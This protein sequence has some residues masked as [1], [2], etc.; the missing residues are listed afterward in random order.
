MHEANAK[1]VMMFE[2]L[3]TDEGQLVAEPLKK[4]E[5]LNNCF[6]YVFTKE[7]TNIPVLD[8]VFTDNDQ[9]KLTGFVVDPKLSD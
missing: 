3:V 4:A 9:D 2:S 1:S 7:C 6:S 5:L 8:E